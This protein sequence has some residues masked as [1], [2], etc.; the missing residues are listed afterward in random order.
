M[1]QKAVR[2]TKKKS[3]STAAR[4]SSSAKSVELTRFMIPAV[5]AYVITWAMS[6]NSALGGMV[7]LVVLVAN[8]FGMTYRSRK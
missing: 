6:G 4:R 5:L 1:A 7:F 3:A 2:K 8:W